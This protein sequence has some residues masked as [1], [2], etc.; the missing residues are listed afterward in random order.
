MARLFFAMLCALVLAANTVALAAEPIVP[1]AS[2]RASFSVGQAKQRVIE[3]FQDPRMCGIVLLRQRCLADVEALVP[4]QTD[5]AQIEHLRAFAQYGDMDRY[6]SK[7][8]EV[9][10][11]LLPDSFWQKDPV[12]TWLQAAG[13]LLQS[14]SEL[15]GP[16]KVI[17]ESPTYGDMARYANA[18][19]PYGS[20]VP[21]DLIAAAAKAPADSN[22]AGVPVAS[23]P[24]DLTQVQHLHDILIPR[25]KALFP[26]A[27]QPAV[28]SAPSLKG[29]MQLG[30]YVATAN[31]MFESPTL[32]L[33]P[34]SRAFLSAVS[35]RLAQVQPDAASAEQARIVA[36][37]FLTV[38]GPDAWKSVHADWHVATNKAAAAL[39][40]HR[41]EA[42]FGGMM[43]AQV[44]YNAAVLKE[45]S[46][47]ND[48]M[49][50]IAAWTSADRDLPGLATKRAALSA[51]A[52]GDWHGLNRAATD[53]TLSLTQ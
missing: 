24:L 10:V 14:D 36:Q 52:H 8:A 12:A 53:L 28:L 51:V 13:I 44:A 45:A 20:L 26:S 4:T 40:G 27:A 33:Q 1:T 5:A 17:M 15:E 43:A 48:Q 46:A 23:A 30:A 21:G 50:F 6:D 25:L 9:N 38:A 41:K 19:R 7:W 3:M 11:V 32:F 35:V 34:S 47:A 39:Q 2:D 37:R 29:D 42:F 16:M 18:A 22:V 31:E 49:G